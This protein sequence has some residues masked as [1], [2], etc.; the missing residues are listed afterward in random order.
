MSKFI[1][2]SGDRFVNIDQIESIE[3]IEMEGMPVAI[4][5]MMNGNK[6]PS[7]RDASELM[8]EIKGDQKVEQT[9]VG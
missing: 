4:V 7:T 6:I 5:H 8:Q 2:V 9:W 3:L 1:P